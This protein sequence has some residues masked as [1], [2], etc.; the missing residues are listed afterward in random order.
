MQKHYWGATIVARGFRA[1]YMV[2]G[3]GVSHSRRASDCGSPAQAQL[4]DTARMTAALSTRAQPALP[5]P[6]SAPCSTCL[7]AQD[8]DAVVL[9]DPLPFFR[10]DYDVQSISDWSADAPELP[11]VGDTLTASCQLYKWIPDA[12]TPTGGRAAGHAGEF[13]LCWG[14]SSMQLAQPAG[15]ASIAAVWP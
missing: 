14:P 1:L 5:P 3:C 2:R 12:R 13:E 8:S 9:Q 6:P 7:A 11:R 15:T 4:L 10:P